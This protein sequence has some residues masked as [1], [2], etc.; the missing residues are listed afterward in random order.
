MDGQH[1]AEFR[2]IQKATK[3]IIFNAFR[4]FA[5]GLS[6]GVSMFF[7]QRNDHVERS[8]MPGRLNPDRRR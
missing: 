1:E 5:D 6:R 3:M 4:D 2:T 7:T 8:L